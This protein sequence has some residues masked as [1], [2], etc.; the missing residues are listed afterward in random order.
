MLILTITIILH[1]PITSLWSSAGLSGV[2]LYVVVILTI[3]FIDALAYILVLLLMRE[4]LVYSF[5][6]KRRAEIAEEEKQN[7]QS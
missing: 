7:G 2:G 3:L 1:N 6:K 5:T 4:N